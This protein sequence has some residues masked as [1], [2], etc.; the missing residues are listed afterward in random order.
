MKAKTKRPH[1]TPKEF[2]MVK[3]LAGMNI[4]Y[5]K[6]HDLTGRSSN[7]ISA[8]IKAEDFEDYRAKQ[9]A[10]REAYFAKLDG[11]RLKTGELEADAVSELVETDNAR[12]LISNTIALADLKIAIR[13]LQDSLDKF[14]NQ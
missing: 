8:I 7:T 3:E 9:V 13:G 6:I 5:S 10:Y 11:P 4:S 1:V 14:L 2:N 12:A